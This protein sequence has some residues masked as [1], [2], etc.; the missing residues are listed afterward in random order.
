MLSQ[1]LNT[2]G[3]IAS[4]G[5]RSEQSL[6]LLKHALELALEH[7]LAAA[8]LRA[9]NNLGDLLDRRDRYEEAIELH[10]S[11]LALARKAGDRMKDWRLR[12]SSRWCLQRAAAGTRRCVRRGDPLSR[13]RRSRS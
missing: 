11:G 5:G 13:S 1:A 8:A 4:W 7:D 2:Q 10:R 9:Y 12:A 3:L 6:A